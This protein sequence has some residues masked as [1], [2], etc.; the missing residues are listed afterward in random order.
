MLN[1]NLIHDGEV[2]RIIYMRGKN[3][4]KKSEVPFIPLLKSLLLAKRI[5]HKLPKKISKKIP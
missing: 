3:L 4:K 1:I 5:A 2:N